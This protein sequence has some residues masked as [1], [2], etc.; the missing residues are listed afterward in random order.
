MDE[1]FRVEVQ[2]SVLSRNIGCKA[3]AS[4]V[5]RHEV[6]TCAKCDTSKQVGERPQRASDG[7]SYTFVGFGFWDKAAARVQPLV[8]P[9]P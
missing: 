4:A 7:T 2:V 6:R 1:L 5:E 9:L 8:F 3:T